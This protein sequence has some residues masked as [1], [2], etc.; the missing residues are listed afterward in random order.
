[1]SQ[2][3]VKSIIDQIIAEVLSEKDYF[4]KIFKALDAQNMKNPSEKE[5]MSYLRGIGVS[6]KVAKDI[7]TQYVASKN[8]EVEP[9]LEEMTNSAAIQ[10]YNIPGAFS[11]KGSRKKKDAD[12]ARIAHG[13][14]AKQI[15]SWVD[16][17]HEGVVNEGISVGD[18]VIVKKGA[19]VVDKKFIG[20]MGMVT[21]VSGQKLT[22]EFPNGRTISL[23]KRDVEMGPKYESLNE[24]VGHIIKDGNTLYVDTTFINNTKGVLPNS[25]LKHAG[26]GD[27]YLQTPNG[28][29]EFDRMNYKKPGMEGRVHIVKDRTG[30]KFHELIKAM[31]K[32]K[33]AKVLKEATY[34]EFKR[35]DSLSPRQKIG[36]KMKEINGTLYKIETAIRQARKLKMERGVTPDNYWDSTHKKM[37]KISERILKIA[38]ELRE[39]K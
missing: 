17:M 11:G 34:R 8:E 14:V 10:G 13:T 33:K 24:G 19:P 25:E 23:S 2:K 26:M 35:D 37:N 21:S 3:A 31:A 6:Y 36:L 20:R 16:S 28:K 39:M 12:D 18:D 38:R 32:Q 1:M 22:V 7:A 27:F 29:I 15:H 30:G 9:E 4:S 5:V